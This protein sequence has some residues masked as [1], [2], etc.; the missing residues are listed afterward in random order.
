M[1]FYRLPHVDRAG[2]LQ[3]KTEREHSFDDTAQALDEQ[4]VAAGKDRQMEG[5]IGGIEAGRVRRRK[6]HA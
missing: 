4:V 2:P 1:R 5:N 3:S 6:G